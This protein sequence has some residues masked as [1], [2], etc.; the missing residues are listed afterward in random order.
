MAGR[1]SVGLVLFG[2]AGGTLAWPSSPTCNLVTETRD[3]KA[4]EEFFR[5]WRPDIVEPG[6]PFGLSEVRGDGSGITEARRMLPQVLNARVRGQTR[7]LGVT[8]AGLCHLVWGRCCAQQR[9]RAGGVRHGAVR[10]HACG[11]G[12]AARWACSSTPCWCGSISTAP[13]SRQACTSHM[14]EL[15]AHEHASLIDFRPTWSEQVS[16]AV[17]SRMSAGFA[18]GGEAPRQEDNLMRFAN[19]SDCAPR[20]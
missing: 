15:L 1:I 6:R 19:S 11:A 14:R 13:A 2:R 4:H 3:A 17:R 20:V 16:G 5:T 9:P 7:R 8:L 10:P 18:Y 12:A